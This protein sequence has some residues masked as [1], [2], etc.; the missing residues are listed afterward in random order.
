MSDPRR[1]QQ[2]KWGFLMIVAG[3][4]ALLGC[5]IA[6][7]NADSKMAGTVLVVISSCFALYCALRCL[8]ET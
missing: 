1:P 2:E 7:F 6:A 3:W 4:C 5:L 8:T